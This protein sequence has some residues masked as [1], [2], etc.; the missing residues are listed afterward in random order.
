MVTR[1]MWEGLGWGQRIKMRYLYLLCLCVP[2]RSSMTS[3]TQPC[4][5]VQ[6]ACSPHAHPVL[7]LLNNQRRRWELKHS[8]AK[9]K[10]E[11]KFDKICMLLL[12]V[13][14]P[15][16]LTL[17][18]SASFTPP[19]KVSWKVEAFSLCMFL[20][21]PT[22][23]EGPP[24]NEGHRPKVHHETDVLEVPASGTTQTQFLF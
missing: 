1:G 7:N 22:L 4:N 13:S 14:G 16:V 10:Q 15:T 2:S 23:R 6:S 11:C 19:S 24:W 20:L 5:S 12:V 18:L 8:P 3:W 9:Q 17:L 21:L